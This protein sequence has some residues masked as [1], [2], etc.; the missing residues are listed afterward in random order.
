MA[1]SSCN[2]PIPN[3]SRL[4][5]ALFACCARCG[6]LCRTTKHHAE[7]K[8]SCTETNAHDTRISGWMESVGR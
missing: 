5:N 8:P 4:T 6:Q 3:T 7:M 1:G 2:R